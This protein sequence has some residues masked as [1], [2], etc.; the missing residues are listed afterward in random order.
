MSRLTD[1][2]KQLLDMLQ[3]R[4]PLSETPFLH[5]ADELAVTEGEVI[6]N[7]RL[8]L[9]QGVIRRIGAIINARKIGYYSTLCAC[10]VPPQDLEAVA[11]AVSALPAVTHNYS[12]DHRYNLWFTLS[13]PSEEAA[14]QLLT[15][16]E[17]QTGV[18]MVSMPAL[19]MYKIDA[20][21]EMSDQVEK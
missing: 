16:L 17:E 4:F 2:Q 12:R 20:R 11:K 8:L 21:F 1:V 6:Y 10:Q 5:L 13:A 18:K 15:A 19:R 7:M 14:R 3:N 9:E